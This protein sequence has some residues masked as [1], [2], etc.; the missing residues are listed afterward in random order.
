MRRESCVGVGSWASGGLV[1]GFRTVYVVAMPW[2]TR[3][4]ESSAAAGG[5]ARLAS[6]M[7]VVACGIMPAVAGAQASPYLTLDD[8]RLPL[9]EHLIARGDIP[10][11]SPMMRPFRRLDAVRALGMVD[12][13]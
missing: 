10:D 11:P 5:R 7:L 9:L 8:P 13:T 4:P 2:S 1:Y 6:A 12:T 3:C